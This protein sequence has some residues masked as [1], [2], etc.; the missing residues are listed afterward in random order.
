[1]RRHPRLL[2]LDDPQSKGDMTPMI[3]MVFLLLIFFLLTSTFLVP[4][5]V[6]GQLLPTDR[7]AQAQSEPDIEPPQELRIRLYPQGTEAGMG[8]AELHRWWR[9]ERDFSAAWLQVG[10]HQ[11]L[12]ITGRELSAASDS[13]SLNPVINRIH[14]YIAGHLAA[15]EE[16]GLR[17]EQR[18]VAI[19][20][21]SGLSWKYALVAY[22]AVR[23]YER[24]R[25]PGTDLAQAREV[26]LAPPRLRGYSHWEQG[27]ELWEIINGR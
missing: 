8:V 24:H 23:D 4:E 27:N 1:M 3:D 10:N 2:S 25:A 21:F 26:V 11:P 20:C 5:K 13:A 19:H 9:D 12:L 6:I 16:A 7:G 15:V 17:R 14:E 18:N 22:D